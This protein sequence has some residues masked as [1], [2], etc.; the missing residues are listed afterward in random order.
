[1]SKGRL[2]VIEGAC[3]GI[4]K[5][6]QYH[7][8]SERLKRE[9]NR[10]TGHHFPSYNMP[11]AAPVEAYLR[12]DYGAV[13]DMSPYFINS[14][15]AVDR[16]VTWHSELK[17]RYLDGEI[18]LLDR[19]TTSSLIY[20]G[21]NLPEC[22]TDEFVE[23]IEDLEYKKLEI[24]KPDVV[25][26]LDAPFEAAAK[27]RRARR[28]NDGISND[29]HEKNTEFL[30]SVHEL[31]EK[32]SCKLGWKRILCTNEDGSMRTREAIHDD[33]YSALAGFVESEN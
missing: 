14:L 8:L 2:I 27:L 5:S 31:S 17:A 29:I 9:G 24:E 19:Y 16:A 21:A 3:D 6:T 1:M 25:I 15:Y 30:R 26:F 12:G 22:E 13:S 23:Y 28:E 7:L 4:G 10:V 32:L 11:Q 33:V 20:Q 18:I